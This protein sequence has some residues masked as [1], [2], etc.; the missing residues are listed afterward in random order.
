MTTRRPHP[1][2]KLA[3]RIG[4]KPAAGLTGRDVA[5]G[6]TTG[7]RSVVRGRGCRAKAK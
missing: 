2:S 7:G 4:G 6:R 5:R 3:A 1:L